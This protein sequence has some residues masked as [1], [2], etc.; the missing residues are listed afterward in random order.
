MAIY[1]IQGNYTLDGVRGMLAK[2]SDREAAV[3]PLIES[4][5]G[6][7]LSYYTTTGAFDFHITIQT[8]DTEGLMAALIVASASGGVSN[9]QTVQAFDQKT[10]LA[11]QTRAGEVANS[12]FKS[13]NQ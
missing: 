11:A 1:I 13:A 10:F 9:M 8:D 4:G 5:G 2:P 12:G 7:L 6:K 3:R